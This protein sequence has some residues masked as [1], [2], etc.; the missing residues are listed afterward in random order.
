ML[1]FSVLFLLH[2]I[3]GLEPEIR[4]SLFCVSDAINIY[5]LAKGDLI[6]HFGQKI[7]PTT[8]S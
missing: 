7:C 6:G 4:I 5:V 1:K 3:T 8:S 2:H